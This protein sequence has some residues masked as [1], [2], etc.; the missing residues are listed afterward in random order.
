[1]LVR[2]KRKTNFITKINIIQNKKTHTHTFEVLFFAVSSLYY[3][4]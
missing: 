1:M 4:S 2:E 3:F